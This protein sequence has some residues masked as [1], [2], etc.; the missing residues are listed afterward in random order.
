MSQE[1]P[2]RLPVAARHWV[3]GRGL[4]RAPADQA[5]RARGVGRPFRLRTATLAPELP[6]WA[7]VDARSRGHYF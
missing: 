7:H 4:S 3:E 6:A 1:G 2:A 5:G